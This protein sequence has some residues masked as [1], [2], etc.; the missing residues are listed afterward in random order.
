MPMDPRIRPAWPSA[1]VAGPAFSV[2][3]ATGDNLAVHAAVVEAPPGSVLVVAAD[4]PARGYWGELLT[5]GAEARGI[6][7]LVIDGGVRDVAALEAHGFPVFSPL[8]ALP[9][10][11]KLG[12]GE[13]GS[14]ARVGG[15]D[16]ET[17]DW[18]VADRDGV[19]VIA[20][21]DLQSTIVRGKARAEKEALMLAKLRGGATTVELLGLDTSTVTR[22]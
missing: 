15:V 18:I 11:S 4:P 22:P 6:R 5:T 13:I 10:A 21:D 7:G 20:R 14:T 2:T 8:I 1:M 16:V 9:G 3:C 17:G 19:T 12:G